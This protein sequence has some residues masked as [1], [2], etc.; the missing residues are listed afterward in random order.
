M[1]NKVICTITIEGGGST[2][3]IDALSKEL[4]MVTT[5]HHESRKTL[6]FTVLDTD[7]PTYSRWKFL[8]RK[9]VPLVFRVAWS[10]PSMWGYG[11]WQWDRTHLEEHMY[12]DP[13]FEEKGGDMLPAG[14]YALFLAREKLNV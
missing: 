11:W 7:P 10:E 3:F 6:I 4:P 8:F 2:S 13:E 1:P 12:F 14:D 5:V 9:P